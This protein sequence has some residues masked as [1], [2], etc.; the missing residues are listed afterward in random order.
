MTLTALPETVTTEPARRQ[1]EGSRIFLGDYMPFCGVKNFVL[2][3]HA[4]GLY[5][6]PIGPVGWRSSRRCLEAE[7]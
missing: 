1:F 2:L 5:G 4:E 6:R 7:A 3:T